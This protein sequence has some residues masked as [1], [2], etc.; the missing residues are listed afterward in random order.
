MS[1]SFPPTNISN[2]RPSLTTASQNI[3]T[4]FASLHVPGFVVR[5]EKTRQYWRVHN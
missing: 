1:A 5:D 3:R 4:I 2:Y